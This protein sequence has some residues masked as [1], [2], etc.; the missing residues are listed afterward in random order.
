MGDPYDNK[1]LTTT[2][3]NTA[4]TYFVSASSAAQYYPSAPLRNR[5]SSLSIWLSVDPMTD[6]YP[7]LS[8]YVYCADNPVRIFDPDG[9]EIWIDDY[10]YVPG[11]TCPENAS[12]YTN[13]KWNT[14]NAIYEK[15][16]G[17]TLINQMSISEYQFCISSE[18]SSNGVGCYV[19]EE[20][21]SGT[22]YLNGNNNNM[23]FM[24]HELFHGYQH[25]K[26][27]PGHTI[28][29]E[30]EANMFSYSI[31]NE[32]RN[33]SYDEITSLN[34]FGRAE[35]EGIAFNRTY[36]R[37]IT[38]ET[39]NQS[40]F[41]YVHDNFLQWSQM[42]YRGTYDSYDSNCPDKSLIKDFFPLR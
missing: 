2:N 1:I 25:M 18:S 7:N 19:R 39:F 13:Q 23:D 27:Q 38:N 31:T 29:N 6:K 8:P 32:W 20:G 9:E 10:K 5:N 35:E 21:K 4:E 26:G 22:I 14:L 30:I 41:D 42:N 3:L 33:F 16:N 17:K 36:M 12:E 15:K 24:A 34:T 11:A 37:L 40:D 28:F